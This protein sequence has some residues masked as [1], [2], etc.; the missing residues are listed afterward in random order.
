M[1]SNGK[2]IC[3]AGRSP[4]KSMRSTRSPLRSPPLDRAVSARAS[5]EEEVMPI[6]NR[7][8][9]M[10]EEITAW[11]RDFHQNPELLYDVHRTAGSVAEKLEVFGCDEVVA[12]IGK[13][14]VVGIIKGR[15]AASGK[16]V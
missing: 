4:S 7:I 1:R 8:A 10:H 11:R 3:V 15:N 6:V 12:G 14:G 13:T 16:V 5:T 2:S 9:G